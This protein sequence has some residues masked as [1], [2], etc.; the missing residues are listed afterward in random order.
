MSLGFVWRVSLAVLISSLFAAILL[1]L[2]TSLRTGEIR[3]FELGLLPAVFFFCFLAVSI[4]GVPVF[5]V[6]RSRLRLNISV[7]LAA[8]FLG[9]GLTSM[10]IRLPQLPRLGEVLLVGSIGAVVGVTF[11]LIAGKSEAS[12]PPERPE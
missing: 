9:G 7:A 4:I 2:A 5:F 3:D 8:G 1:T 10:L 11:W 6:L 12:A